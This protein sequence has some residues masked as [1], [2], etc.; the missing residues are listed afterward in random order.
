MASEESNARTVGFLGSR[1]KLRNAAW[2]ES[3][4]PSVGAASPTSIASSSAA[5][6]TQPSA[7]PVPPRRNRTMRILPRS[8]LMSVPDGE[9]RDD[10]LDLRAPLVQRECQPTPVVR[11]RFT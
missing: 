11:R 1:P 7:P 8:L 4:F 6:G 10:G 9:V 3:D 2:I 5:P